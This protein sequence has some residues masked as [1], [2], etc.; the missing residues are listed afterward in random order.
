MDKFVI[1]GG[2]A[3]RGTVAISAPMSYEVTVAW[4]AWLAAKRSG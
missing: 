3:L 4:A 1:K 2:K